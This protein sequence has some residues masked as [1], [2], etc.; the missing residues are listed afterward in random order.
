MCGAGPEITAVP[1]LPTHVK[2]VLNLRVQV[3]PVIDLSVKFGFAPRLYTDRT[4][5][6]VVRSATE[7]RER[8]VG[9]IADGVSEVLTIAAE[10]IEESP[11]F[12]LKAPVSYLLGV[13]KVRGR[14]KLLLDV[15]QVFEGDS[16]LSIAEALASDKETVCR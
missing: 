5:I 13:A 11:S 4:C 1:N 10:D 16:L 8:L 6:V 9:A 2:G 15:T 7:G 3:I 14:V 12:G